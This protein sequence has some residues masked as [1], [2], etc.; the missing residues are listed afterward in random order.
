MVEWGGGKLW[1]TKP[2]KNSGNNF[3]LKWQVDELASPA[4]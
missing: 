4:F 2:R 1:K 3:G